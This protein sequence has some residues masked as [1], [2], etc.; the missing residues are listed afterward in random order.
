[1]L[2]NKTIDKIVSLFTKAVKPFPKEIKRE[3]ALA[4][5]NLNALWNYYAERGV[6]GRQVKETFMQCREL[7]GIHNTFERVRSEFYRRYGGL[8]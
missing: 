1:M 7:Y 6:T 5:E 4:L 3:E 8:R 2:K